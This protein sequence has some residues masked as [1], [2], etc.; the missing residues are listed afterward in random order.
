[1][2]FLACPMHQPQSRSAGGVIL[3]GSDLEV[4][5]AIVRHIR[6]LVLGQL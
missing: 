1:M 2:G 5:A 4:L 6:D 3:K